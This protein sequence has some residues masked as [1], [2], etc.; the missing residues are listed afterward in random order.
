MEFSQR[1]LQWPDFPRPQ[2]HG[3]FLPHSPLREIQGLLGP[4]A[5]ELGRVPSAQLRLSRH[6]GSTAAGIGRQVAG[7]KGVRSPGIARAILQNTSET[8]ETPLVPGFGLGPQQSGKIVAAASHHL[9]QSRR[10]RPN[11]TTL[12]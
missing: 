2:Y 8:T 9:A 10:E 4:G 6:S 11:R 5:V 7:R 3:L 1:S 12:A